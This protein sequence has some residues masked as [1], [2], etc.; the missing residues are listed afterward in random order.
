LLSFSQLSPLSGFSHSVRMPHMCAYQASGFADVDLN[1]L[2]LSTGYKILGQPTDH[3]G[4][5][6]SAAQDVNKDGYADVIVGEEE[7]TRA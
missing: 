7:C 5:S 1:N 4:W 3:L 2:P 6:V